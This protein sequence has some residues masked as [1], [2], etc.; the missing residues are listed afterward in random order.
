MESEVYLRILSFGT[1]W[2]WEV[3]FL[4]LISGKS[5]QYTLG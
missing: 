2:T 4:I 1:T 5:T 3:S